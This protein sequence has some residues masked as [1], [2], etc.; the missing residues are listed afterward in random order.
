MEGRRRNV[1][2]LAPRNVLG[3]ALTEFKNQ[4]ADYKAWLLANPQG[5][6]LNVPTLT[7]HRN[8]CGNLD[9]AEYVAS[10]QLTKNQKVCADTRIELE[11]WALQSKHAA[12]ARACET[13]EP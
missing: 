9:P 10:D 6:I 3:L 1:Y 12:P 7:L 5:F 13:C 2:D 11:L 4:D 8:G